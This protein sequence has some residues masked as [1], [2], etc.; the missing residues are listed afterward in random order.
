[1]QNVN[2]N[3]IYFFQSPKYFWTRIKYKK[4]YKSCVYKYQ[5]KISQTIQSGDLGFM[6]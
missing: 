3:S 6:K 1:M 2:R 5:I 4:M